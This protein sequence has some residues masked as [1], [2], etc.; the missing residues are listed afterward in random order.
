MAKKTDDLA[1]V[2]ADTLNK[3]NKDGKVA[4]FLTG[5][6][7]TED[8]P[9]NVTDW[10]GTGNAM[11][12]VAISNRP[13]GGLP[14][15][16]IIEFTGLE[17]TGK[18]LIC[19]HAL[20]ETQKKGGIAVL[21]DTEMAVNYEFYDAIGLD[22]TKLLYVSV[23]TVEAIFETIETIIE[24]VRVSDKDRLVTIVVDSIA[25]ASTKTEME[26]DYDKDGY[27]T[28]KAI[29]M[30]KALRKITTMIGEQKICLIM[31]NQLRQKLNAPAFSD[32][33][34]TPGGKALGFHSSVRIRLTKMGNI[35]IGK[36][37]DKRIIGIYVRAQ[38]IK[39]RMGP[40]LRSTEMSVYF[41]RGIDN[42]GSWLD[43]LKDNDIVKS[44]GAW[45]TYV[46]TETGEEHKF[47]A[48]DFVQ[49]L[50]D[51][52]KLKDQIY[53]KI[54]EVCILKYKNPGDVVITTDEANESD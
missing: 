2:L 37:K 24:K 43:V 42:Y 12:D 46:D 6:N 44:G 5:D 38:V 4:Y 41:D 20:A 50:N 3:K 25:A 23:D 15:G 13:Y 29:I 35:T 17:Q 11:L 1:S 36:D 45:V 48:K 19:A 49:L 7:S 16:R 18:S 54:C 28:A 40:P 34:T 51:D 22:T 10:V 30:S 33:W 21:I 31:T 52:E 53:R 8:S 32:P 9:T 27:A 39:N 14:V 47:Q 26:A